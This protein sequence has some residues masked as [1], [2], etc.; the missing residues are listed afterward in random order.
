MKEYNI[1]VKVRNNLLL[2]K[3]RSFG[4]ENAADLSKATGVKQQVIGGYLNLTDIPTRKRD[5]EFKDSALALCEH[6]KCFPKDIFPEN[7]IYSTLDC[8][9]A[10]TEVSFEEIGTML[11]YDMQGLEIGI[12]NANVIEKLLLESDLR[13]RE[14]KVIE[15]TFYEGKTLDGTAGEMGITRERV[16][17]IQ[18]RALRRIRFRAAKTRV[19]E[20]MM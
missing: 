9:K 7:H 1:Q 11:S 8:N 10:E 5:G 4:Y 18:Q 13:P 15:A 3:M 17:Q 2:S 16:R 20:E 14:K 19:Y 12:D 6:F